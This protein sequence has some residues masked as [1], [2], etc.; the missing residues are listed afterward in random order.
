MS[1]NIFA[2]TNKLLFVTFV[3]L[4]FNLICCQNLIKHAGKN[5][6]K[7]LNKMKNYAAFLAIYFGAHLQD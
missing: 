4:Y 7:I 2:K 6:K 3:D 5:L 1:F